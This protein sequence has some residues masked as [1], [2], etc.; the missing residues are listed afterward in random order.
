MEMT[1][2]IPSNGNSVFLLLR[3]RE[4][5][6]KKRKETDKKIEMDYSILIDTTF[7]LKLKRKEKR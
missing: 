4:R 5:E 6:K 3:E 1:M 7:I 2:L